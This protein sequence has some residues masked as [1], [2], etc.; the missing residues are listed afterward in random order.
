MFLH[1]RL[2]GVGLLWELEADRWESKLLL[3]SFAHPICYQTKHF[4]ACQIFEAGIPVPIELIFC[5]SFEVLLVQGKRHPI[6]VAADWGFSQLVFVN[7]VLKEF[8]LTPAIACVNGEDTVT[9][10]AFFRPLILPSWPSDFLFYFFL[11]SSRRLTWFICIFLSVALSIRSNFVWLSISILVLFVCLFVHSTRTRS[12]CRLGLIIFFFVVV[13]PAFAIV[14][15]PR[16]PS[17]LGQF[18]LLKPLLFLLS[19]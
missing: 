10:L 14:V 4:L 15:G 8:E 1:V 17:F 3:K 11:L 19:P 12:T 6:E 18:N 16:F 9:G 5:Y 7:H 2:Q 13:R